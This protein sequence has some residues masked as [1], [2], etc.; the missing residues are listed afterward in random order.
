VQAKKHQDEWAA[1]LNVPTEYTNSLGVCPDTS[2]DLEI[3][4]P[5][6]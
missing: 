3:T 1:Y 4:E 2:S 6:L 5:I